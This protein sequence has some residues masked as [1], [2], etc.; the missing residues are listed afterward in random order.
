[1]GKIRDAV[2]LVDEGM[3]PHAAA[4]EAGLS[5]SNAV[6]EA[7]KIRRS[8]A[9]GVC[10]CCGQKLPNALSSDDTQQN[11]PIETTVKK[12]YNPAMPWIK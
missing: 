4:K 8:K 10:H 3:N 9:E 6:Y 12:P 2:R 1:M 7:L 5:S 11:I